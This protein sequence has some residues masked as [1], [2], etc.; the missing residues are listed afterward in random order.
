MSGQRFSRGEIYYTDFGDGIGSEQRG[1]RPAVIISNNI[2]NRNSSTGIEPPAGSL[3][4]AL[5]VCDASRT[6][7]RCTLGL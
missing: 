5:I 4:A 2:G 1:Y 6:E 3:S 7:T